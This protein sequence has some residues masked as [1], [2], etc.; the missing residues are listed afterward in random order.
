MILLKNL[1]VKLNLIAFKWQIFQI[2]SGEGISPS[3]SH[4]TVREDLP[5]H[6]SS[7]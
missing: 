6:G 2:E 3:P 1:K 7:C 4:G 5:S